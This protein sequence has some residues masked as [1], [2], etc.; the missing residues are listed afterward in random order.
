MAA[1][2]GWYR[3][4][5]EAPRGGELFHEQGTLSPFFVVA[6]DTVVTVGIVVVW[7]GWCLCMLLSVVVGVVGCFYHGGISASVCKQAREVGGRKKLERST[8]DYTLT[9]D[10]DK[11]TPKHTP[12]AP[13]RG[14]IVYFHEQPRSVCRRRV[15]FLLYLLRTRSSPLIVGRILTTIERVLRAVRRNQTSNFGTDSFSVCWLWV[16]VPSANER[17][18]RTSAVRVV[19]C[20]VSHPTQRSSR[21]AASLYSCRVIR[22]P[23]LHSCSGAWLSASQLGVV[24]RF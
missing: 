11:Q 21:R 6:R 18:W 9:Q 24:S 14:D 19:L 23:S 8:S 22:L 16:S 7:C 20:V 13:G 1:V 3:S 5:A 10:T 4:S 17:W 2:H 15:D 12:A